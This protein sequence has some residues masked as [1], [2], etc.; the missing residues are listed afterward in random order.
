MNESSQVSA[1]SR[2]GNRRVAGLGGLIVVLA[3]GLML[4]ACNTT[5]GAGQDISATGHDVT[6]AAVSVKN[7]L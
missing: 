5:A 6:K 2:P 3:A 1:T 4:S 7:K